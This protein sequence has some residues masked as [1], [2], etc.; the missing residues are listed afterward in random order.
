[1]RTHK[2]DVVGTGFSF[3]E[4]PRWH[5][6][7]LWFSDFYTHRVLRWDGSAFETMCEVPGQ[8]SGLGFTPEGYLLVVSMTDRKLLRL[9]D[10]ALETVAELAAFCPGVANDM[11]VDATGRAYIGN[12]GPLDP[13]DSTVIVCVDPDGSVRVVA[14][15]VLT[16]NGIVLT[17]DG[18]RLVAAESFAGRVSVWTV[19]ED[20]ALTDRRVWADFGAPVRAGSLA[21]ARRQAL[22]IPDGITLNAAGRLWVADAAGSGVWCLEEGGRIVDHV[23]TGP[24]TAYS[25]VLGGADGKTLFIAAGPALDDIRR[26]PS[27]QA[28][29]LATR[30]DV[31][32]AGF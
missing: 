20:G 22:M 13:L 4:A 17:P 32:G 29:I 11:W 18:R 25:A 19:E 7:A 23:D 5:E 27:P 12:D 16:P 14:R 2:V 31:P 30:V 9:L 6:G 21:D 26:D 28:A 1:M 24:Y 10:G 8:P 15:D 3:T